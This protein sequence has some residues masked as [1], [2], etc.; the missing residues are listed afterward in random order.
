MPRYANNTIVKTPSDL[1]TTKRRR[2]GT[3]PLITHYRIAALRNPTVA[4]RASVDSTGHIWK[5]GDRYYPLAQQYYGAPEYWWVI[6]WGNALPTEADVNTGD[7]LSIPLNL[8]TALTILRS[9]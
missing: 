4:E 7:F 3:R 9:Y 6:A 8:E 1:Y 5:Y 2:R